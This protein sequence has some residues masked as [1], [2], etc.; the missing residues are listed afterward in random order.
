M[1]CL[2]VIYT[3]SLSLSLICIYINRCS[4]WDTVVGISIVF[5]LLVFPSYV[6]QIRYGRGS[7]DNPFYPGGEED[8]GD[9]TPAESVNLPGDPFAA[10]FDGAPSTA[11]VPEPDLEE[12]PTDWDSDEEPA[13]GTHLA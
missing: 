8:D 12:E 13:F 2:F 1:F 3:F 5:V 11:T 9:E 10:A 7:D 6:P 4:S